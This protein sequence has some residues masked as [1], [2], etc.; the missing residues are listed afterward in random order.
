MKQNSIHFEDCTKVSNRKSDSEKYIWLLFLTLPIFA[1][2]PVL[3]KYRFKNLRKFVVLLGGVYGLTFIPIPNSDGER[4]ASF[5]SASADYTLSQYL[6]DI[7]NIFGENVQFPDV[8]AY[9]LFYLGNLFTDNV[10]FFF[11]I[12]GLV[13][14]TV[15]TKL[16]NSFYD[17][18]V[19]I[20]KKDNAFFFLGIIF[21]LNFSAGLNGV[22]W[23][24]GL[25]VFLLGSYNLI[26][27]K[28][29]KFLLIAA[30]SMMVHFALAPAVVFLALF[31]FVP[32]FRNR[33]FLLAFILL[34]FLAGGVLLTDNSEVLGTVLDSKLSD[35]TG[36]GYVEKRENTSESWN[37]YVPIAHLG[38]YY[39]SLLSIFLLWIYQ[40]KLVTNQI[41]VNLLSFATLMISVAFIA[42]GVVD[43]MTN[44]YTLLVVF[45]TLSTLVYLGFINPNSKVLKFLKYVYLPILIIKVLVSFR[46]DFQTISVTLLTNPIFEFFL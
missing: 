11:M 32:I 16:I 38:T 28:K 34:S 36:E 22:R 26:T 33:N 39:F 30:L 25:I 4:F 27:T 14:F 12:T 18:D 41:S 37:W 8:Y 29:T 42:G 40:R 20:L 31:H 15:F 24:L 17:V 10:Q 45:A 6:Y 2:F 3:K 21:I 1:L 44:R 19:D 23:P 46:V 7:G 5:Y 9:T 13:Y 43:I 35:Y